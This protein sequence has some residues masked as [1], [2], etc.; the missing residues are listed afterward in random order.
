LGVCPE[1]VWRARNEFNRIGAG[2][3]KIM[4]SGGFNAERIKL[5]E[6]LEVPVDLY[7]VGSSLLREKVDFTADIVRMDGIPCA[8]YGR[9][10]GDYS[11]LKEV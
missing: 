5:Y 1:L 3:L 4:V 9:G 10:Q 2:D 11:R 7:G 6:R 8:K